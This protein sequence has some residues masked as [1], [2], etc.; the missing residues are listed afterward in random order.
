MK[1]KRL[2]CAVLALVLLFSAQPTAAALFANQREIV[3]DANCR[4]PVIKVAVPTSAKV[5]IN[6]F[7]LPVSVNGRNEERQIISSPL[8]I[9][10]R[11][12]AAIEVDVTVTGAVKAE[13]TMTLASSPT[14][15]A[16]T[17]KKAFVYFEIQQADDPDYDYVKWDPVYDSSKHIVVTEGVPITKK[18]IVTL[19]A[20]TLDNE[21][22]PGGYAPFRLSGDAVKTPANAWTT[23]DGL[24]VTVAFTFTPLPYNG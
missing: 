23:K 11:S 16:G 21:V 13:S 17:D 24:N 22:A 15:G 7:A 10:N 1:R 8:W 5:Y 19:P 14:G 9:A 2:L 4:L 6:P 20:L 12:D 3:I 18:N